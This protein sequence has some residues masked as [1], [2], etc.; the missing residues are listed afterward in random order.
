M[1]IKMSQMQNVH[2]ENL[3]TCFNFVILVLSSF[4][5]YYLVIEKI[6]G[7]SESLTHQELISLK[8]LLKIIKL[9]TTHKRHMMD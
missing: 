1:R 7:K 4:I 6:M 2:I 3:I 8:E 5:K 9:G